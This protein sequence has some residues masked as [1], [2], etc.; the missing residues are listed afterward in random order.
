MKKTTFSKWKPENYIDKPADIVAHLQAALAEND[1]DFLLRTIGA[2]A[3]SKGMT[4]LARKLNLNRE[5]LYRSFGEKG[6]P[7]FLPVVN[8]LDALGIGLRFEYKKSA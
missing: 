7:S 3:R 8:M 5:S 4:E 1:A 2:I 6:N